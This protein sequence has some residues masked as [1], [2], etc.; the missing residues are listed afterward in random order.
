ML[1]TLDASVVGVTECISDG[2]RAEHHGFAVASVYGFCL[3][4]KLPIVAVDNRPPNDAWEKN[5]S[6]VVVHYE[7]DFEGRPVHVVGVHLETV[8]DGLVALRYGEVSELAA[9][10]ELRAWESSIAREWTERADGPL[11]VMGDFNIP[12]ESHIYETYW[13]GFTN[14]FSACGLGYGHTK[15]TRWYGI[16]IDHV[17]MS[18]AWRCEDA[19]IGW[20]PSDHD[21][22][23]AELELLPK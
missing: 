1:H 14:A 5:G 17:L 9:N 8:R 3:F 15:E 21:P 20:G 12:V 10:T 18:D 23:V 13:S 4:S 16:R 6:G 22:L 7:L 19:D 2:E 11:I